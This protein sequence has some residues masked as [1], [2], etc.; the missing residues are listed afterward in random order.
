[1]EYRLWIPCDPEQG[2]VDLADKRSGAL[3]VGISSGTWK[4]YGWHERHYATAIC[5][6]QALSTPSG[7]VAP[8]H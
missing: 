3:L 5:Q 1:M 6:P 4:V 7:N 2:C 8:S